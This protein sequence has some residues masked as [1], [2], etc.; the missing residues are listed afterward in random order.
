MKETIHV[1]KRSRTSTIFGTV[2]IAVAL[3]ML[4]SCA[5][6][7][8]PDTSAENNNS[9]PTVLVEVSAPIIDDAVRVLTLNGDIRADRQVVLI[10]QVSGRLITRPVEMGDTVRKGQLIAVVDY[11]QL[12][13]AVK[14]ARAAVASAE[15]QSANL[16]TELERIEQLY[17][18]GG[19]SKQQLDQ[20]RTHERAAREGVN[21][22]RAALEQATIMRREAEIRAPFD[23]V[24][25]Q[26]MVNVGDMIAP[27]VPIAIIVERDLLIGAVKIPERDLQF[28][29]IGQPVSVRVAAYPGQE[30]QGKIHRI[31]PILDPIT[32]MVDVEAAIENT[33]HL[34][35]PGMFASLGIEVA[36][37]PN[38]IM[39]PSDAILQESRIAALTSGSDFDR[40]YYVYVVENNVA[41]RKNVKIGFNYAGRVE[42]LD[43]ITPEDTLITRGHHLLQNG[44]P[45]TISSPETNGGSAT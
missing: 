37:H 14:Q 35:K 32:R 17:E 29:A 1:I 30:F 6:N 10:S 19:A 4:A 34:L 16:T 12:D 23:G 21:Q 15:E 22:A 9:L 13:L 43:G 2:G 20:I 3:V 36:R 33:E 18:A 42:V 40:V 41:I 38:M 7:K 27:S 25:G 45:V 5:K 8:N 28:I 24:V 11:S 31:S 44:Q 39:A 26:V